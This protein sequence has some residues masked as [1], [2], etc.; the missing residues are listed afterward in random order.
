MISQKLKR[1]IDKFSDKISQEEILISILESLSK[2]QKST[3]ENL[4]TLFNI[5][6]QGDANATHRKTENIKN[7]IIS[8]TNSAIR[9]AKFSAITLAAEQIKKSITLPS[10]DTIYGISGKIEIF[11]DCF[12]QHLHAPK[13][14]T[15][16]ALTRSAQELMDSL[17][18]VQSLGI[19]LQENLQTPNSQNPSLVIYLPERTDLESFSK[20]TASLYLLL[21]S[22]CRL[23]GM[24]TTEAEVDIIKIESGSFFAEISANPLVVALATIIIT[25]GTDYAFNYLDPSK[26]GNALRDSSENIQRVLGLRNFLVENGFDISE[27]DEEI[28]KA[29]VII[30]KQ[31]GCL[32]DDQQQ[33]EINHKK[34]KPPQHYFNIEQKKPALEDSA[35][36]SDK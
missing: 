33:I 17:Y 25:K 27:M 12:D 34:I 21:E 7:I 22:S 16:I 24:S 31:L 23:L 4:T 6:S 30:A 10:I 35:P 20:K 19:T 14:D 15:C 13:V 18:E 26:K 28:K 1:E 36:T 3:N 29:S 2:I 8:E 11:V 5:S 32:I 9:K